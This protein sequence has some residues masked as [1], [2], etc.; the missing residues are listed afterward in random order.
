[1][2]RPLLS[3]TAAFAVLAST[4]FV[5]TVF[6]QD[7]QPSVGERLAYVDEIIVYTQKRE[8]ISQD[9]PLS[10]TAFD[11]EQLV[12]LGVQQFDDLADYVPG[13]EIQEQSPNNPGFVIRGI[14]SDS[15]EANIEPR[16]T[17][18]QDGVSLSRS[19]GS[20]VELFDAS[21][22]VAK[23]P[24]STLFGR[25]ALIGAINIIQNKPTD[26]FEAEIRAGYGNFDFQL[27]DG[28]VNIPLVDDKL[29][30]RGAF[31]YK[32]RDGYVENALGGT[33]FNGL[34]MAA[35]RGSLRFEPTD[36]FRADVIVNYQRDNNTGTSFKSGTFIPDGGRIEPWEPAALSAEGDGTFENGR[37]LG[38][39][40]E[41]ASVTILGE[42]AVTDAIT[43]NSVTGARDFESLEVFDP[44]GS[45]LPILLF[46]EDAQGDQISQEF[47]VSYDDGGPFS[48]FAGVAYFHESGFQRVPLQIDERI[49]I[50]L[51][52]GL[53]PL[54]TNTPGLPQPTPP[55]SAFPLTNQKPFHQ[56]EF[57]NFG[58]TDAIDIFADVSYRP[59]ERLEVIVGARYTTEDKR[60]G[61]AARTVNGA[62][63]IAALAPGGGPGLQVGRA[64]TNNNNPVFV[65]DSFDGF[66]WRGVLNYEVNDDLNVYFN[67]GRG[68]R[69]EVID[70]NND[71]A[72]ANGVTEDAFFVVE[73]ETVD[74]YEGGFKARMF[75]G[76]LSVDAAGYYYSYSNFQSSI[77]N[78]LGVPLTVNAGNADAIGAEAFILAQPTEWARVFASYAYTN[79][80]FDDFDDDGNP[81]RFAGNR[82]RLNPEHSLSVG[83]T[84]SYDTEYGTLALTPSY[85]YRTEIF[86]D[87]DN[88]LNINPRNGL[89]LQGQ[90]LI[91]DERQE[92]YGIFDARLRFDSADNR[93]SAEIFV[94][95]A[96]NKEFIIDAGNTGDGFGIP[97]FIAGPPRFFGGYLT[98]RY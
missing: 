96:F 66:S 5:Q 1:M 14:T 52:L 78:E 89:V 15:G 19:R 47:R 43:I 44:D 51:Q 3:T 50:P 34:E 6:A 46:A 7:E 93:W 10:V 81:Q 39:D 53:P 87:E 60:A 2:K 75:D 86:F 57:T 88:D 24:Q 29:A 84:F 23:G 30:A 48:G 27:V 36:N 40:R 80:E 17:I 4:G 92:A 38:L 77:V 97:T 22:E 45:A 28:Y 73:D 74:S 98:L 72:T 90:D 35:F 55:A 95:N 61:F 82:F 58:E 65:E 67:Y 9:V 37:G 83:G 69:P 11:E 16:V 79:T 63:T 31:R 33:D 70:I 8:Q 76:L 49:A 18:F 21:V 12:R 94:E 62:S 32:K 56:E 20:F 68:R 71:V 42:W 59:I 25:S 85:V 64:A 54:F 41:V 91:Q 13:L 26:E